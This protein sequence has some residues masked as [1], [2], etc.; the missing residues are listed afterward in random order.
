VTTAKPKVIFVAP[1]DREASVT[2]YQIVLRRAADHS[3][4]VSDNREAV[5]SQNCEEYYCR[6]A[7]KRKMWV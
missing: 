5:K 4:A 3:I 1:Q 6:G 2:F 7:L